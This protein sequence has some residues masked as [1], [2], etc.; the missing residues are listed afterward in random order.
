MNRVIEPVCNANVKHSMLNANF[1]LIFAT[2]NECMFDAIHDLCVLD[3]VN[4]VNVRS[5]SKSAKSSKKKNIWKP[6]SKV[7][8][9]IGYKWK[10]IGRTFT[11]VGNTCLLTRITSTKVEPLKENTSKS[12]TTPNPEINIYRRKTK[13]A[14][15]VDLISEPSCPNCSLVFD[16]GC[17]NHMT[18]NRSQLINFVYKFLASNTKSWLWHRRLSHLN[19]DTITT[20]AKQGLVR[21]LP[22]LEFHKDHLCSA[23][24]LGKSKKHIHKPKAE[25]SIQEKLYLL[26]MDLCGPM[27]IQSINGRK[28]I[29]VIVDDYS[30]FTWVKFLRSKDEVPEFVIKF[31]K[32]NQVRLNATIRNIRID[33]GTEFIN[34]TLRAY[35]EDVGISHQTSVALSPQQNGVVERQNRTLVEAARTMLIFSKDLLFLWAE[36]IAT[37]CYTQNRS[38]IR[39]CH[40]K[41]PYELLHNRK[42]ALSYLLVFGALCYPTNDSEDLGMLKPKADIGIFVGYAPAKKAYRIYNKSTRLIIETIHVDFDELTT[43]ASEQFSS[44]PRPHLLT[45]RTISSGLPMFDEYFNPTPCVVS[46]FPAAAALRPADPTGIPSSTTFDQNASSPKPISKESSSRDAIP[47]NVHSV[48]QPSEHLSKWTKDDHWIMSLAI[49]HDPSLQ[50][51]NYK[52]KPYKGL[53]LERRLFMGLMQSLSSALN[54]YKEFQAKGGKQRDKPEKQDTSSRSGNYTHKLV[55]PISDQSNEYEPFR[56]VELMLLHKIFAMNKQAYRA[57]EP[58]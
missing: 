4:D 37:A 8:T 24:A 17:S 12:V 32:M 44:G 25:D 19:F 46:P 41:T 1:E 39:K 51:I 21:G 14:K 43:I 47:T 22:K 28:Y 58:N 18:G 45:L 33:N 9:D 11:I 54:K 35:Y 2:C 3:F 30:W 29:L 42:P 50:D 16:S 34:Q 26:H 27:R 48:N 49:P 56:E 7:F 5:K 15:S 20:L 57:H 6:T 38:L 36:A 53:K 10:P 31:I 40:N 52:M 13:V 55:M 23:C